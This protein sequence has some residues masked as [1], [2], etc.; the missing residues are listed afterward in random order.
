MESQTDEQKQQKCEQLVYKYMMYDFEYRLLRSDPSVSS[1]LNASNNLCKTIA[2]LLSNHH[3]DPD[4]KL[5]QIIQHINENTLSLLE[6]NV[7][8]EL[9]DIF[10][11]PFN[12]V[13][14]DRIYRMSCN[15]PCSDS[16]D[17]EFRDMISG[18]KIDDRFESVIDHF[19]EK[20]KHD[21]YMIVVKLDNEIQDAL[22]Q[23]GELVKDLTN[24]YTNTNTNGSLECCEDKIAKI[25]HCIAQNMNM[26]MNMN[27]NMNINLPHGSKT[28]KRKFIDS[29]FDLD[30]DSDSD[31]H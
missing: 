18:A 11:S 31:S 4:A 23:Y 29:D 24:I 21:G 12:S 16:G 6:K 8:H 2:S 3:D 9:I 7:C 5:D 17:H 13:L 10:K 22:V 20:I 19:I 28:K 14:M 1:Q 30:S 15:A 26:N 27:V 25:T